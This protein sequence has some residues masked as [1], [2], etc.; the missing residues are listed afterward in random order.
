MIA[1]RPDLDERLALGRRRVGH[2]AQ[3][4]P[5]LLVEDERLH[6]RYRPENTGARFSM[7]AATP[8]APSSRAQAADEAVGLAA[9]A[10]LEREVARRAGELAE[11]RD[12]VR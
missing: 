3:L 7:N 2:L 10:L 8:S 1:G 6:A 12:G 11:H 4:E 9:Q 5:P